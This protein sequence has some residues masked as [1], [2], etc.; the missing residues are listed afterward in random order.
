LKKKAKKK[1]GKKKK[2]RAS[3]REGFEG[4]YLFSLKKKASKSAKSKS[5]LLILNA[6]LSAPSE[7]EPPQ[8]LVGVVVS[9]LSLRKEVKRT[10]PDIPAGEERSMID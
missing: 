1:G 9:T 4:H 10:M 7:Q 5:A 8:K 3:E 6:L 2:L